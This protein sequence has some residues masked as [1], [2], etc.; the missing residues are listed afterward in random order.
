MIRTWRAPG[1][2]PAPPFQA[3][4]ELIAR[5]R[6]P[7][8]LPL[9][10]RAD[11]REPQADDD[12][13]GLRGARGID[14]GDDAELAGE[15]GDLLLQVV[16]HAQIAAEERRFTIADVIAR[17]SDKMVRRHPHVFGGDERAH[18]GEVL[19]NWEASRRPSSARKGEARRRL[20]ARQRLRRCPP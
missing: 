18:A 5:L 11:P 15:L 19:R 12:R 9:G 8:R 16:F 4:V 6:A 2:P 17:V 10:P 13:G 3:F 14:E 7:G 1:R 20:D